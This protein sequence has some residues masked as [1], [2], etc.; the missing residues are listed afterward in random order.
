[1][2]KLHVR[3]GRALLRLG[4]FDLAEEAFLRVLGLN[5]HDLL[6]PA[7]AL[8]LDL[9]SSTRESLEG[10]KTNARLGVR[11]LGKLRGTYAGL[12]VCI[13]YHVSQ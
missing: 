4:N 8:D 11:D 1:M 13:M 3:R 7:E 2:S 12:K 10:N 5:A 9:L 6:S